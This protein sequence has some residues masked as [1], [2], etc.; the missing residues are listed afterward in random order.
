LLPATL[1]GLAV[2]ALVAVYAER[3]VSA[4]IQD[5]LGPMEVGPVGSL[6]T[7]A[8]ILKL[9][10]KEAITPTQADPWLFRLGPPIVFA[11]VFAGFAVLPLAPGVVGATLNVGLLWLLAII[12]IDVIGI[13]MAGWGSNNKYAL[14]GAVR[15]VSQ[16]VSYEIP[17]GLALLAAAMMFGSLDLGAITAQQGA[18]LSSGP[19]YLWGLWDVSAHGGFL[20]WGLVRYPHLLL[21]FLIFYIASLAESNRAPFDIPEAESELVAGFHT[22]Y[23]GFSFA[24]LML[25]EYAALLLVTLLGV[26][27]FL[28]GWHTPL[29]NLLPLPA[30]LDAAGLS[31]TTQWRYL[32]LA[33]LTSGPLWGILWFLLKGSV[34]VLLAMWVRWTYPRLRA[35]QLMRLCWQYLTPFALGC[36]LVSA[37]WKL[38][39]VYGHL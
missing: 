38:A 3:K 29:P 6:Q 23:S 15:S 32:Q 24:V 26:V 13:L 17:S 35:D 9:L 20:S 14:L 4:F 19:Q 21:A 11:S 30:G 22:E 33:A 8:D 36:V 1:G 16:I 10:T 37:L 28:G 12:S 27:V 5:R 25:A 2:F 39:E 18:H 31:W 34:L 7:L